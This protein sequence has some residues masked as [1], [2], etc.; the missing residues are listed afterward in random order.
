MLSVI[1]LN[2]IMLSAVKLNV[3][4]L[5]VVAPKPWHAAVAKTR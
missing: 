4:M 1:M 2:I 5:S 3:A